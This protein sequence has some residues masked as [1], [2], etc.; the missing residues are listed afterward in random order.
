MSIFEADLSRV[1]GLQTTIFDWIDVG[2]KDKPQKLYGAQGMK[3]LQ[4]ASQR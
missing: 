2:S 3:W 1:V 4:E